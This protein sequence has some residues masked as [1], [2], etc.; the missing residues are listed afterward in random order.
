MIVERRSV[1]PAIACRTTSAYCGSSAR[2]LPHWGT[3]PMASVITATPRLRTSL[4]AGLLL[5]ALVCRAQPLRAQAGACA[6]VKAADVAVL[7]GGTSTP[8]A[9]PQGQG[10]VWKGADPQRKLAVLSYRNVGVSGEMAF[11]GARNAAGREP[12]SKVT[13]ENGIGD[14]AF[15]ITPSFGAA[16]VMVKGGRMLQLQFWTGARG[17]AKDRDALRVVARKAVAAF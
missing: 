6:L 7:L 2:R 5:A 12:E 4:L 15:S 1:Q 13:D 11:T 3:T 16:F 8:T 10:C 9:T 14:K 17:T